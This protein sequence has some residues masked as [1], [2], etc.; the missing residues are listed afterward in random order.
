MKYEYVIIRILLMTISL[1]V[2]KMATMLSFWLIEIP[3][4]LAQIIGYLSVIG[5]VA[6]ELLYI[7]DTTVKI[8]NYINKNLY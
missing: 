4:P 7:I 3:D 2:F 8:Y 5:F 1:F 6:A